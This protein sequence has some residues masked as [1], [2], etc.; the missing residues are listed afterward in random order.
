MVSGQLRGSFLSSGMRRLYFNTRARLAP[1]RS[2]VP[3]KPGKW[4]MPTPRMSAM[5]TSIIQET[6]SPLSFRIVFVAHYRSSLDFTQ[7]G[8]RKFAHTRIALPRV[9]PSRP[10]RDRHVQKRCVSLYAHFAPV[11][12]GIQPLLDRLPEETLQ[13]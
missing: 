6:A 8:T 7:I 10:W 2:S 5:G 13:P 9:G 4:V 11:L 12:M 1:P 3:T